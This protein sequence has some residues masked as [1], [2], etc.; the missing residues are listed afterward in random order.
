MAQQNF[1]TKHL[2]NW[3]SRV[4]VVGNIARKLYYKVFCFSDSASYWDKRYLSGGNSGVGSYG[5]FAKFKADIL[6]SPLLDDIINP[7]IDVMT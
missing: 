6:N 1:E 3:I 4:P 7:P 2:K 5:K